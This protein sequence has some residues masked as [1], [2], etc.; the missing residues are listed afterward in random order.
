MIRERRYWDSDCFLGWLQAEVDKQ[1]ACR[2]VLEEANA[3]NIIIVTSALT[4]AEVLAMRGRAK[5][6]PN[7]RLDVEQFFKHD[8]IAVQNLTRRLAEAARDV[9][10]DHGVAPKD[11]IHVATAVAANV[12]V[13]N[14]FDGDLIKKSG[15]IGSPALVICTPFVRAPRLDLK[16]PPQ[17]EEDA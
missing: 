4:I 17:G 1:E 2:G 16:S 3:G 5:L 13:M 7:K 14:T 15:L 9:V 11:A 10:L 12:D 6:A 8:Y